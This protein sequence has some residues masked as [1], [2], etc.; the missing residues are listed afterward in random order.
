MGPRPSCGQR[1]LVLALLLFI[2]G[3]LPLP[4]L[5]GEATGAAEKA[6]EVVRDTTAA[7]EKTGT[8]AVEAAK[9][10]WQRVDEARLRNRTRDELVAW[11]MMG[12]LVGAVAGMMTS[13]KPT[14]LGKI[15]RLALGL[16]GAFLGGIVV[17]VAK[18]DFGWGPVLIRYEELFF[19]LAGAIL[20][21]AAGRILSSRMKKKS[22][23]E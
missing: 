22:P 9:E 14:G 3:G 18:F 11:V 4:P 2:L 21:L 19:S 12:M 10:M 17:H 16:V 20:I 13:L 5:A 6:K 1:P 15:G 23:P 7:V 8:S